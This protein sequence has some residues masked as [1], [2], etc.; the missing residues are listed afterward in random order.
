M[1]LIADKRDVTLDAVHP[2]STTR[3]G[4]GGAGSFGHA[5]TTRSGA[6]ATTVRQHLKP[7][8]KPE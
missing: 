2:G 6:R 4:S 5:A 3:R 8:T 1:L 7:S